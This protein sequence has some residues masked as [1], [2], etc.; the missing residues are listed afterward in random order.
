MKRKERKERTGKGGWTD[1]ARGELAWQG[2]RKERGG[3]P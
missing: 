2:G 3:R 1:G